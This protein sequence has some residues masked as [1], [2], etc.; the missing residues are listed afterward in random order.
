MISVLNEL[1][2]VNPLETILM[3]VKS[4][5]K[6]KYSNL[7]RGCLN[8]VYACLTSVSCLISHCHFF[9]N[10]WDFPHK[11]FSVKILPILYVS[12]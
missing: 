10:C 7:T 1:I 12:V 4:I 3:F 2:L 11:P 9:Q 5:D 8:V 6:Y